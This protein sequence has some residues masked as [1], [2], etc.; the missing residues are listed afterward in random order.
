[1]VAAE[2]L[3]GPPFQFPVVGRF[4]L[5]GDG[6][7]CRLVGMKRLF[8]LFLVAMV[9]V[10]G[11]GAQ[12][13]TGT[14]SASGAGSGSAAAAPTVQEGLAD[15]RAHE[16]A[17]ALGVFQQ[18]LERDPNNEA[19]NWLAATAALSLYNG[20]LAVKYAEKAQALDPANWKIHTTLVV[21]Y[22]EAGDKAKRDAERAVLTKL[23]DDPKAKDA[24][25][26]AGFLLDMFPVKQYRVEAI[27]YFHP[28]GRFHIYY[29]FIVRNAA[30]KAVWS[31]DAASNDFDEA[32]WAK[33]YPAR[34]KAGER[35]FELTG[36]G[37]GVS[38]DYGTFSGKPEYALF[39]SRVV[40]VLG[41]QTGKFPGER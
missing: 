18:V 14:A 7:C 3:W 13:S 12:T 1:M 22:S 41:Q 26:T 5:D 8:G 34:A 11:A 16:P 23:H 28:V 27:E 33:A 24:M 29:H 9:A 36:Q 35:Q 37:N 10:G 30:G 32:S 4:L 31:F 15:L 20:P 21:A 17:H 40:F 2:G 25:Q 38:R 6:L 39:K 19:A